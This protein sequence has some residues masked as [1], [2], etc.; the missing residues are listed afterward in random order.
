[1]GIELFTDE[2]NAWKGK[3]IWSGVYMYKAGKLIKP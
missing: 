1:M 3:L 2:E